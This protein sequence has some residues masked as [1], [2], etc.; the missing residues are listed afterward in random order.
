MATLQTYK[1]E[2]LRDYAARASIHGY[3]TQVLRSA[4]EGKSWHL[5]EL[6]QGMH[7]INL[8][9]MTVNKILTKDEIIPVLQRVFPDCRVDYVED[10][11]E[12]RP[13]TRVFKKGILVDWS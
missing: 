1:R 5:I 3:T 8:N 2:D 4:Q 7:S 10:W 9:T 12:T 11:F 13:D 6:N